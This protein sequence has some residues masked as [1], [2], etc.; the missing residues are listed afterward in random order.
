LIKELRSN[1]S[2]ELK[3]LRARAEGA[4]AGPFFWRSFVRAARAAENESLDRW[5]AVNGDDDVQ[6]YTKII[7]P[8]LASRRRAPSGTPTRDRRFGWLTHAALT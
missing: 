8:W 7:R 5:I 2:E 6:A 4:L 1:P 3:E